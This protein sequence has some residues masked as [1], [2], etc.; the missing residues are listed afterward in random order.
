MGHVASGRV[1]WSRY[2]RISGRHGTICLYGGFVKPEFIGKEGI[3]MGVVRETGMSFFADEPTPV[4]TPFILGTGTLFAPN[5]ADDGY[6]ADDVTLG[7][8]PLDPLQAEDWMDWKTLCRIQHH[9]V[10]LYLMDGYG[11]V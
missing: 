5:N 7:L 3:L 9:L 4:G 6:D 8:K 11:K 2:E 10:N 1:D